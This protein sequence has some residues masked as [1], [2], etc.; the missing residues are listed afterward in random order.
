MK[1]SSNHH[2][3][4]QRNG[5]AQNGVTAHAHIDADRVEINFNHLTPDQKQFE[6]PLYAQSGT[7]PD[8]TVTHP[9]DI[10][11]VLKSDHSAH[12]A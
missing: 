11:F 6:N 4:S 12:D 8:T 7:T 2:V 9:G 10:E 1:P 3:T 5:S